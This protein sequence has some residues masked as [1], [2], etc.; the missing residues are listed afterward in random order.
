MQDKPDRPGQGAHLPEHQ[1]SVHMHGQVSEVQEHLIRGQL[2]LDDIIPVDGDDGH[3][4]EQVE[5][6][7]LRG[8]GEL[9]RGPAKSEPEF[10]PESGSGYLGPGPCSRKLHHP[11]HH[12]LKTGPVLAATPGAA[13]TY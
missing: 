9:K 10:G 6:V 3:T 4:D 7:R 2:L 12:P 5:V 13:G 11:H 1:L 8:H